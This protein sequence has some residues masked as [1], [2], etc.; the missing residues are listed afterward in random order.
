MSFT[1]SLD[2]RRG[3]AERGFAHVI[4]QRR[5]HNALH[6]HVTG[7]VDTTAGRVSIVRG[8]GLDMPMSG[9]VFQIRRFVIVQRPSQTALGRKE[10]MIIVR[11]KLACVYNAIWCA[12]QCTRGQS[13]PTIS[14]V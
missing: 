11:F 7:I 10:R 4:E 14:V 13:E 8:R 12:T 1:F 5:G 6:L 9:H 2:P 3:L